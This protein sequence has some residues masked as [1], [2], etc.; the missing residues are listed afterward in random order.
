[1]GGGY[2]FWGAPLA[3]GDAVVGFDVAVYCGVGGRG[4]AGV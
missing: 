4:L 3:G 1:M 2:E